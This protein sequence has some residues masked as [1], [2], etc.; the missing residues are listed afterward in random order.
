MGIA[1][2]MPSS[3]LKRVEFELKSNK[4]FSWAELRQSNQNIQLMWSDNKIEDKMAHT[5]IYQAK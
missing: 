4:T 2:I 5:H 3:L 1:F